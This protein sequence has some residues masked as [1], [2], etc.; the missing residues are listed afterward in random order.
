MHHL[1]RLR[2]A[3]FLLAHRLAESEPDEAISWYAVGLWYHTG[4][5][6][7]DARRY[8]GFVHLTSTLP[9]VPQID[10]TTCAIRPHRIGSNQPTYHPLTLQPP[11]VSLVLDHVMST[12]RKASL[13]N[14][15]FGP[16]WIAF[17]HSFA[18]EKEHD[19][20]ITAYST[21]TRLFQG[22]VFF[23]PCTSSPLSLLE[24]EYWLTLA[25]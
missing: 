19:Q 21:A 1:P 13:M 8:F 23:L 4:E 7:G 11:V 20:A 9:L 6:W 12:P 25:R 22:Y 3:L 14:P 15:R 10:R 2:S 18:L 5:R 17:A 16:A 24:C